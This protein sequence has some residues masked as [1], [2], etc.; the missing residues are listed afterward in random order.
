MSTQEVHEMNE[1][2]LGHMEVI[3]MMLEAGHAHYAHGHITGLI[4]AVR[5]DP[6]MVEA[7]LNWGKP[8]CDAMMDVYDMKPEDFFQRTI[9]ERVYNKQ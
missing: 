8:T 2:W 7:L 9:V 4:T 5:E 6:S 1:A 3:K